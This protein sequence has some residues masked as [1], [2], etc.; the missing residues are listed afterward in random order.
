MKSGNL[1]FLEPSGPLQACNGTALPHTRTHTH[2]KTSALFVTQCDVGEIYEHFG[3]TRCHLQ[4]RTVTLIMKPSYSYPNCWYIS[5]RPHDKCGLMNGNSN[6][7]LEWQY[8]KTEVSKTEARVV[9]GC[10]PLC[11]S[12]SQTNELHRPTGT[13]STELRDVKLSCWTVYFVCD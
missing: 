10:N 4:G 2:K 1:N 8:L 13:Y 3:G 9:F 5:V 7:P 11:F 6:F 12:L